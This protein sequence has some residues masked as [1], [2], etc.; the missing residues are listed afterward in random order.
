MGWHKIALLWLGWLVCAFGQPAYSSLLS[1][2][3]A[4]GGYAC[5]WWVVAAEER[6][7]RRFWIGAGWF[8]AVQ[9]VQ[10]A[11][12]L[13]HPYFYIYPVYALLALG[14]GAQFGLVAMLVKPQRLASA[15]GIG[16]LAGLWT[17]MEWMRLYAMSGLSWNPIGL[18]LAAHAYPLQL[19]SWGG[20]FA[21]SFWVALTSLLLVRCLLLRS[22]LSVVTWATA[23]VLPYCVGA[24]VFHSRAAN[25]DGAA[26]WRLLAI[27]TGF[28][29]EETQAFET[30][31]RYRSYVLDQWR[32]IAVLCAPYRGRALDVVALPEGVVAFGAYGLVHDYAQ[33]AAIVADVFGDRD[34]A[35]LPATVPPFGDTVRERD[36]RETV[37][38]N[39]AFWAQTLAN[40]LDTSVLIGLEDAERGDNGVSSHYSSALH[41]IPQCR[42][43]SRERWPPAER[44]AKRVLV[45]MGE[46]IPFSWCRDVALAYGI[47]GSF[48]PGDAAAVFACGSGRIAPS[49]CYE[50]TFGHLMREGRQ[51]GANLFVNVTNDGW[52]PRSSLPRQHLEHARLRTVENGVPLLRACSTGVTAAID[53]RGC[54]VAAIADDGSSAALYAEIP[55]YAYATPYTRW[56]DFPIVAV[57]LSL[58]LVLGFT[59]AFASSSMQAVEKGLC[60]SSTPPPRRGTCPP[61][62]PHV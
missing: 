34:L 41:F 39:N 60:P 45:P 20:V 53:S 54:T 21:L 16:G 15:I 40:Y 2:V 22:R 18:A 51:R 11:W 48:T 49:I 38:V 12:F 56:G 10:L 42:W 24:A 31:E 55:R 50:E 29:P 62:P 25:G 7:G 5:V 44:Y 33:A 14:M 43:S 58:A 30:M 6:R 47:V 27:Q 8:A 13:S 37:R 36:G 32:Q 1:A 35:L 61:N 52:F 17:L 19:V 28:F 26:P 4:A 57:S 46:Y 3:T 9:L 59:F 23:A